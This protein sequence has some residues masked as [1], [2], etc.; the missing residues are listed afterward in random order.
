MTFDVKKK[1]LSALS[2]L[3]TVCAISI[4]C[5]DFVNPTLS[6]LL[7]DFFAVMMAFLPYIYI[8]TA[9]KMKHL[10]WVIL[11]FSVSGFL[12]TSLT[13]FI[14]SA[15][16][17]IVS[18]I[19]AKEEDG[20]LERL[21]RK[22]PVSFSIIVVLAGMTFLS[23]S[24]VLNFFSELIYGFNMLGELIATLFLFFMIIA[25]G[26]QHLIF[27]NRGSIQ[28]SLLVSMPFIIFIFYL[29]SSLFAS[30]IVEGYSLYSIDNIIAVSLFYIFVGIFEDFL[31]RG[32][33][34]NIL[35]DKFGKTKKGVWL[36]VFLS[37]LFFGLIHFTNL[38]T[39]A[40]FTGVL[41]QVISATCIGMYFASIYLRSGS[42]WTPAF[43]H[44]FYDLAVSVPSFFIV[45]E[46]V[47]TTADYAESISNYSW[48]NLI[49]AA[50]Y[51]FIT[52]YLLRNNKMK[53]VINSL[54]G[55]KSDD[56]KGGK[57]VGI[58]VGFAICGFVSFTMFTSFFEI[59]DLTRD[60]YGKI[61][62]NTDYYEDYEMI[63]T[64]DFVNYNSLSDEAKILIAINNLSDNDFVDS[65]SISK[66]EE[67][68]LD[69]A[70]FTYIDKD[71][72][73]KSLED[74]FGDIESVN[75]VSV[76]VSYKT[77]CEY[78]V[79][80]SRY[81][82]IT[83][84]NSQSNELKVYSNIS[85]IRIA[86]TGN[87]EV[88]VYYLVEDLENNVLYADS[89]L[90]TVFKYNTSLNDLTDGVVYIDDDK[91]NKEFWKNIEN[92]SNGKVP[93]YKLVFELNETAT[94]MNFISSE[95]LSDSIDDSTEVKEELIENDIYLYNASNYSFTY[96]KAYYDVVEDNNKLSIK[97][98]DITCLEITTLSSDEWL[99]KYKS[100]DF[101]GIILGNYT[102]YNYGNE[103]LIYKN[104]FYIITINTF[105]LEEKAE[106]IKIISSIEFK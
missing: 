65:Y 60:L 104:D 81:V 49:I 15:I 101:I 8:R 64:N 85:S 93:T 98:D 46:V 40:S 63:Y 74:I 89:N 14:L 48:T 29:G 44:G 27:K 94:A 10:F 12:S 88:F 23:T 2:I 47:D 24:S 3:N 9:K 106:L 25:C 32:L 67:V 55:K 97:K 66:A 35:L 79:D 28:E 99:V 102:Y 70:I 54:N 52:I 75:Y 72:I 82:C 43:L 57:I 36:S 30:Y 78:D 26:K 68:V 50:I 39:G 17:L 92:N 84:N 45:N 42:V 51:V 21:I 13:G 71:K 58:V 38:M 37:S 90:N 11:P 61:L 4:L 59:N 53:N 100:F 6:V 91:S 20:A 77:S 33:S 69:D 96:S 1:F 16:G 62:T 83:T 73:N 18:F 80:V 22:Y 87:I 7:L 105:S 41:I 95:F 56:K 103:Y 86:D 34:L 31:I 76:N 19:S 5:I